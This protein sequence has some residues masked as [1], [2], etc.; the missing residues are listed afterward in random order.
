MIW[1]GAQEKCLGAEKILY[2]HLPGGYKGYQF[3]K[4]PQ[5]STPKRAAKDN[6]YLWSQSSGGQKSE[7]KM[8][9][10]PCS[11]SSGPRGEIFPCLPSSFWWLPAILTS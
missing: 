2:L 5:R 10:G 8:S 9:A 7:I 11:L 6:R 3:A 1:A 4:L